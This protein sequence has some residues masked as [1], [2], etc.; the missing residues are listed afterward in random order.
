MVSLVSQVPPTT[1]YAVGFSDTNL[2]SLTNTTKTIVTNLL[3]PC[4]NMIYNA[5]F[6]YITSHQNANILKYNIAT[7]TIDE[8]LDLTAYCQST[9]GISIKESKLY[10]S[11]I[12]TCNIM[13]ILLG[14]QMTVDNSAYIT[15]LG[16]PIGTVF[17]QGGRLIIAEYS[18]N[19]VSVYDG[20]AL[21]TS[22]SITN[23]TDVTF[24]SGY[25]FVSSNAGSN[26]YQVD[27]VQGTLI[28]IFANTPS[29]YDSIF[30]NNRY[31][32]ASFGNNS[33]Y[34]YDYLIPCYEKNTKILC[35]KN[36]KEEYITISDLKKGDLVKTY[37]HGFKKIELIDSRNILGNNTASNKSNSLYKYKYNAEG[38]DNLIITGGHSIL[39]DNLTNEGHKFMIEDKYLS[40][41]MNSD[42]FEQIT[43]TPDKVQTV[44]HFALENDCDT[45]NYGVWA[46]GILSESCSKKVFV[47]FF[48]KN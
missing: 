45:S 10:V 2:Y 9:N 4:Y 11:S 25:A 6:L 1:L 17:G 35:L 40:F 46:N 42:D 32:V 8:I 19:R 37:K 43:P 27:Y 39:L 48:T 44:Y 24:N 15:G 16:N 7:N 26:V 28:S 29:P 34:V 23:P 18:A 20:Q 22:F 31:Y 36:D 47:N 33:V 30:F 21:Y 41:A 14:S 38:F 12:V 3:Q 13:T 5:G